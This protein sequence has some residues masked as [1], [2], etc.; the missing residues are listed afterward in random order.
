MIIML[1]IIYLKGLF[2]LLTAHL[3]VF[4]IETEKHKNYTKK[5]A[6]VD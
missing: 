1:I 6:M 4:E 5:C 3:T 2:Y